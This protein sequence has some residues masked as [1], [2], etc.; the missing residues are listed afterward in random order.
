MTHGVA[1]RFVEAAPPVAAIPPDAPDRGSGLGRKLLFASLGLSPAALAVHFFTEADEVVVFVLAALALVPLAWLIG[2]ATEQAS[3]HTGPG[4]SGFLNASF[5]N[6][7]ELIIAFLAIRHGLPDIVR[8]S[9]AGSIVS[10]LLLV[11]GL[12]MIAGQ[13]R[14]ERRSLLLQLSVVL[15]AVLAFLVPAIP[16]WSGNPERHGLFV[17]TAPVAAVLIVLYLA[18][19]TFNLRR[20]RT[21]PSAPSADG[22]W[23]MRRALVALGIATVATALVSEALV[24]SLSSFGEALGLSDFFV[25][26]VIVAI[27]G[28]AAEHGGAIVVARRGKTELA[29]EIAIASSA[30]VA[31]FVAPVVALA[32]GLIGHDLPLS[33][34]PVELAAMGLATLLVIVTV[35]GGDSRRRGGILLVAAYAVAVVAFGIAGDR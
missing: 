18:M 33:F 10:N 15:V 14:I 11:L 24:G 3:E 28:N 22:G 29:S 31:V 27:V 5:G 19:S 26:I 12:T 6:A 2:E 7:P 9:I 13:G 20:H 35:A 34:R 8:G 17:L 21:A 30:Q 4:I 16:G 25:A 32:S 23:S 1:S